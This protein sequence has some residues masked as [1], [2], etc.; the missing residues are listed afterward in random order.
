M[1]GTCT[2][3]RFLRRRR[4]IPLIGKIEGVLAFAFCSL[5]YEQKEIEGEAIKRGCKRGKEAL[6]G[7]GDSM[8]TGG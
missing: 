3:R 4:G 8:I 7:V 2:E 1:H 5:P 6:V